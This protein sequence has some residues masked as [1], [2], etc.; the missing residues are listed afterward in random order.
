MLVKGALRYGA[1]FL[2]VLNRCESV[3]C[4]LPKAR[5]AYLIQSPVKVVNSHSDPSKVLAPYYFSPL[6]FKSQ[7]LAVILL[8]QICTCFKFGQSI[9]LGEFD[10]VQRASTASDLS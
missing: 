4:V 2:D 1:F 8:L 10:E 3:E 5:T 9:E 7:R 6:K